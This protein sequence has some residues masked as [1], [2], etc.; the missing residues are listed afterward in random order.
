MKLIKF[1]LAAAILACGVSY[2]AETAY[3]TPVGYETVSLLPGQYNIVGL[4]L[5]NAPVASGVFDSSTSTTLVD[6]DAS[7]SLDANTQYVIESANG[8]TITLTGDQISGTTVTLPSGDYSSYVA[9][10]VV[11]TAK[12]IADVFGAD[13]EAGLASSA[14]ADPTEADIIYIPAGAGFTR[15]FYSTFAA[16]PL[17][18]GWLNADTFAQVPDEV[19]DPSVGFYVQTANSAS[20]IDLVVSGE[21]KLTPT[22]YVAENDYTLLSSVY[23]AGATLETSGL[24]DYVQSSANADPT[25]ADVVFLPKSTGGFTRAFYSTFASD[26]LYAG[27]LN[28]DTFGQIP[29][30]AMT[31]GFL[32]EKK[33]PDFTGLNSPPTTYDSL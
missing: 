32:I 11:R 15:V 7:F 3:T 4:R 13:N 17:Y 30:E 18:A 33:G 16:D 25:E 24:S 19:L 20:S 6:D 8:G 12:T 5:F 22:A 2:A 10:Y 23:P 1:T 21:V 27:W 28:A 31:S 29:D 14:N 26:P 9:S